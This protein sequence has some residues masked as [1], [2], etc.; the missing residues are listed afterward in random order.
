MTDF[1]Y[2]DH[3]ITYAARQERQATHMKRT[4]LVALVLVATLLLVGCNG[5]RLPPDLPGEIRPQVVPQY[6]CDR[7][8][9]RHC[10]LA[11][12]WRVP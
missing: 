4:V 8:L 7:H 3:A 6:R 9:R 12:D 2:F 5:V 11:P 10:V 1:T